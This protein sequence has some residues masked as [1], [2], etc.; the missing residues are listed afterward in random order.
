MS[1]IF[2]IVIIVNF[3]QRDPAG[4]VYVRG[5]TCLTSGERNQ[6]HHPG[7]FHRSREFALVLGTAAGFLAG[8][9]LAV[10]R[11]K[12]LQETGIFVVNLTDGV[13]AKMTHFWIDD[14]LSG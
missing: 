1:L 5:V 12:L 11:Q 4:D 7:A 10:G 2:A 9:D 8:E 13:D 14:G 6:R 3:R